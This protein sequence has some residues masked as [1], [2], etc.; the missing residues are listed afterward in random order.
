VGTDAVEITVGAT[1]TGV[2]KVDGIEVGTHGLGIT[3]IVDPI[4]TTGAEVGTQVPG[5][6]TGDGGS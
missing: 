5:M 4:H 3:A 2:I 1:G 6:T